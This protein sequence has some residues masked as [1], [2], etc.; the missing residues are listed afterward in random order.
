MDWPF[1]W[2]HGVIIPGNQPHFKRLIPAASALI[3]HQGKVLF[4]QR[5]QELARGK[6]AFP[7]GSVKNGDKNVEQTALREIKEEVGLDIKILRLLGVYSTWEYE[8]NYEISCFVAESEDDKVTPSD[9]IMDWKW[10][11][12]VEGLKRDLTKTVRQALE[13]FIKATR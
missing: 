8:P 1:Y 12:P 3:I 5:A 9:E 7:G 10:L 2:R 13:D 4:I 6:W 11:D